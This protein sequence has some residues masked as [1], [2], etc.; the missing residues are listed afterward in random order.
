MDLTVVGAVAGVALLLWQRGR[1]ERRAAGARRA[2]MFD[3]V[4]SLLEAPRLD[5]DDIGFPVLRGTYRGVAAVLEPIVDQVA[6]RRIPTLW[7]RVSLVTPIPYEGIFDYLVR[8]AHTEFY[9]PS[10]SLPERIEVP[11]GWPPHAVIRTDQPERM[12]PF[13]VLDRHVEL[14]REARAKEL[15]ITPRGL[16]VVY[17]IDEA[18]RT[19]FLLLRQPR[20]ENIRLDRELAT[21]LLD[22]LL[23][24][25]NELTDSRARAEAG[26]ASA[27]RQ[28]GG[29]GNE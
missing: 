10:E 27:G 21:R 6:V 19:D 1:R 24:L 12:P 3:E 9:S 28:V 7:L 13:E 18:M 29:A 5:Q 4:V 22:Y 14:L 8:P 17:L 16:R 23:G 2:A 20:F 26:A 25:A 15:L 11:A